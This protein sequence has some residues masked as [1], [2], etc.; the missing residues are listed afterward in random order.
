MYSFK[1]PIIP[2]L[3]LKAL[4][5]FS[6]QGN[7]TVD[8]VSILQDGK[9][10]YGSY[11][12]EK[13]KL[14]T[15]Q[16]ESVYYEEPM[17]TIVETADYGTFSNEDLK[18]K[19]TYYKNLKNKYVIYDKDYGIGEKVK[20]E[21]YNIKW[22]IT[23]NTQKILTYT[24]QEAV[25][26][27]RGRT[28]KAYFLKDIPFQNGPFKF[29]GLPGL[30]LKVASLD[31]SVIITANS[32]SFDK[33]IIINPFLKSKTISW[34]DFKKKY[35]LHFDKVLHYTIEEGSTLYIPKRYIEYF[36]D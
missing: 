28:Y 20:D 30:I 26:E 25:G 13:T 16:A 34:E 14:I 2:L 23:N 24:C 9:D 32:L 33:D 11:D 17:D 21:N 4:F 31:G 36:V 29:D 15:N 10:V 1:N 3:L 27:F 6:Q 18:Y 7:V 5:V 22:T 12:F 35:N 19:F 8:Y